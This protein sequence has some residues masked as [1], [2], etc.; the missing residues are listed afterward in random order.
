MLDVGLLRSIEVMRGALVSIARVSPLAKVDVLPAASKAIAIIVREPSA[1]AGRVADQFPD[2]STPTD[3]MVPPERL[4]PP[5]DDTSET[6]V[7]GSPVPSRTGVVSLVMLSALSE[8][9]SVAA[10][11]SGADGTDGSV[12]SIVT[13]SPADAADVLPTAFVAVAVIV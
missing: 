1:S 12:R 4:S 3:V 8:P 5:T 10:V 9:V 2:P 7:F 6:P 11:R 13:D